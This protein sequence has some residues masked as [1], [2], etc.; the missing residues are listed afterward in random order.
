[1]THKLKNNF[2]K[3]MKNPKKCP[4]LPG[5]EPEYIFLNGPVGQTLDPERRGMNMTWNDTETYGMTY[6][7]QGQTWHVKP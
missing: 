3:N 1:M 7:L 2:P 6:C 4:T 5:P